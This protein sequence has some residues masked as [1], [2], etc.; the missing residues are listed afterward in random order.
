MIVCLSL[1]A[2]LAVFCPWQSLCW[3]ADVAEILDRVQQRYAK[4][5][6]E[7]DFFQEAHLKAMGMVDTAEGHVYFRPPQMMRWHYL[8]PEE[9]LIIT[10]GDMVW[11]YKPA[12]KQVMTGRTRDYFGRDRGVDYFTNPKE[13]T[14][15]FVIEPG[16]E[17]FEEKG[18]H[19]LKLV[20]KSERADL[21]ALYLVISA[22]T[23]E[24]VRAITENTF[25]DRT[26]LRF[27]GYKY[28]QGLDQ[29]LFTFDVPRGVEVLEFE[30][31]PYP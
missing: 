14:K 16:P 7:A 4:V 31:N 2:V 21:A 23:S 26:T 5:D 13:L 11:M 3:G 15:E 29:S 27:S 8:T 19:V 6:F 28:D 24:I 1:F 9:Y 30:D 20:P 25:G 17:G 12:D 10:N 22:E 18:C